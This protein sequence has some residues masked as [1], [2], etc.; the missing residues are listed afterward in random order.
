MTDFA[1]NILV[2][3]DL[4]EGGFYAYIPDLQRCMGDGET[5]QD[6]V[7]DVINAAESWKAVHVEMGREMPEPGAAES[8]FDA[9]VQRQRLKD[10][11][12]CA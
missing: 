2:V 5:P 9:V 10:P 3:P 12:W 11:K 7:A 6:A 1:Y 4:D 8:D